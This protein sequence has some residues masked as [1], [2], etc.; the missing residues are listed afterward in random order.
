MNINRVKTFLEYNFIKILFGYNILSISLLLLF[1]GIY[2]IINFIISIIA[3]M[4]FSTY[5]IKRSRKHLEKLLDKMIDIDK[6]SFII[7]SQQVNNPKYQYIV[8][9]SEHQRAL[10]TP[11][12]IISVINNED[13]IIRSWVFD[14][15]VGI[16]SIYTTSDNAEKLEDWGCRFKKIDEISPN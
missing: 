6:G 4:L 5:D 13:F 16:L 7:Y 12:K 15:E 8:F 9:T 2:S 14:Q 10:N 11:Q 1:G 3:L